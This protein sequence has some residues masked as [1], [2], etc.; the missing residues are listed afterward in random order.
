MEFSG[1]HPSNERD[2][3][4]VARRKVLLMKG[5]PMIPPLPMEYH[6]MILCMRMQVAASS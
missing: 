5:V 4:V 3:I 6:T 1:Y 2:S